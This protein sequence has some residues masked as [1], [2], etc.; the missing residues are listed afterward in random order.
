MLNVKKTIIGLIERYRQFI[1]FIIVGCSNVIVSL[2]TYYI[3]IYFGVYYQLANIAGFVIGTFNSYLLNKN[4][5]F[6]IKKNTIEQFLKFYFTYFC[7]WLLGAIMLF[8]L[9]EVLKLPEII[10]PIINVFITT[11]LHYIMSKFW[12]FTKR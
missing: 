5:V 6:G 12:T 9:V 1:K 4:W 8:F 10:A 11:P 3:F 7:S 2:M